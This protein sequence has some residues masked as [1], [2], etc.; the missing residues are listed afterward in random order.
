MGEAP[1]NVSTLQSFFANN[2]PLRIWLSAFSLGAPLAALNTIDFSAAHAFGW[3]LWPAL[4]AMSLLFAMAAFLV[5]AAMF[6][7][8]V[9]P[10]YGCGLTLT[11]GSSRPVTLSRDHSFQPTSVDRHV[12]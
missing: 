10:L 12:E 9:G 4:L 11:K 5:G 6:G 8:V 7:A 1:S 2:W 3:L